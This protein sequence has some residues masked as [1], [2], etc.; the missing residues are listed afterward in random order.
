MK[1]LIKVDLVII[2]NL[3]LLTLKYFDLQWVKLVSRAFSSIE[4]MVSC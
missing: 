4:G 1:I 2:M 3:G